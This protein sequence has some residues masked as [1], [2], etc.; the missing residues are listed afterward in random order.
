[1]DEI[2]SLILN[3][4]LKVLWYTIAKSHKTKPTQYILVA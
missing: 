2:K 4:G 3:E 1:M